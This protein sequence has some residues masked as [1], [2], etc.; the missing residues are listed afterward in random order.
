MNAEAVKARYVGHFLN[1]TFE[2][3]YGW[4]STLIHAPD[5][6]TRPR[7]NAQKVVAQQLLVQ[8]DTLMGVLLLVS[9]ESSKR[10]VVY[11]PDVPDRRYWREYSDIKALIRAIRGDSALQDYLAQRLPQASGKKLKARLIKGQLGALITRQTI[12]GDLYY[13]LYRAEVKTLIAHSDIVTRSNQELL[14][15]FSVNVL[16]LILDI[17]TFVLPQRPLVALAFG[18]MVVSIWDGFEAFEQDDHSGALHHAVAAIGHATAGLNEMAGSSLMRR[19]LRG[20]PKPPPV[21][22]PKHY[23]AAPDLAR[24][25]YRIDSAHGEAVYEQLSVTPGLTQYF[26]RDNL[27]RYFNV[28]FDGARWRATDPDQPYA[29]L[30]LPITRKQDGNWVV[31]SPVLWHDGLPDI[32]QLLEQCRLATP[33]QG[34]AD[35]E[36]QHLFNHGSTLYLQLRNHQL[37]VRRHLLT[38][39]Y[40]LVLPDSL[41]GAVPAWAVLR[42]QDG[43]WRIRVRQTGR[44]SNWLSLPADYSE[45]RGNSRSSR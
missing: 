11:C 24:L 21:P 2:Q 18:R 35:D 45:S 13:A 9:P 16:R 32:V 10:I 30:K 3:G 27:G 23:E 22:L 6:H 19:A 36:D 20:L 7:I 39:H 14:G 40:H 28:S 44:G 15:E 17:V 34:T 29:Y 26:V 31:D 42:H 33:L 43:E 25:R 37:P 4:A 41:S 12:T 1:D 5:S 8:G 38:G